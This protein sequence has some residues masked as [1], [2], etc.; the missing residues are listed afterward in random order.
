MSLRVQQTMLSKTRAQSGGDEIVAILHRALA[1]AELLAPA[2][3]QGSFIAAG[4]EFQAFARLAKVL[5]QARTDLLI[6]DPYMDE[7]VLTDFAPLAKD[8][9]HIRLLAAEGRAKPTLEPAASRWVTQYRSNRPLELKLA[10]AKMMHDR[11]ILIDGKAAWLVTQSFKDF[12]KRS[13]GSIALADPEAGKM[14]IA[15]YEGIWRAAK[16]AI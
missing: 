6:V 12:A 9:I 3:S 8:G 15:A 11:L 13:H 2:A 4:N 5:E 16:Q 1:H 14:K 7:V 10:D